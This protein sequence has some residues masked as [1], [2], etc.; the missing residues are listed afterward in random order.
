MTEQV[1]RAEPIE[2]VS[3]VEALDRLLT[4]AREVASFKP[5]QQV[6]REFAV[7]KLVQAA[8]RY[9]AVLAYYAEALS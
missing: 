2:N 8:D 9:D 4:A 5:W 3:P 1:A 6:E 7:S